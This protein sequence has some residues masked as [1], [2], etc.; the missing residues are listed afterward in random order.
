MGSEPHNPDLT[1]K[2]APLTDEEREKIVAFLDGEL[3]DAAEH[4]VEVDIGQRDHVRQ[5]VDS[6]RKTWE[7]LDFLPKIGSPPHFTAQTMQRLEMTKLKLIHREK[8]WRRLAVIGWILTVLLVASMAF[9]LAYY[10]PLIPYHAREDGAMGGMPTTPLS[11]AAQ[12]SSDLPHFEPPLLRMEGMNRNQER[13]LLTWI[14]Q[15]IFRVREELWNKLEP[16]ER[17]RLQEATRQGG[18]VFVE[19]LLELANKYKVPIQ[20]PFIPPSRPNPPRD[21][22]PTAVDPKKNTRPTKLD[23]RAAD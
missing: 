9:A 1:A 8:L 17:R 22:E 11:T 15:D 2:P 4:A 19:A 21:R 5:E 6:L 14:Y 7:L 13:L 16:F 20:R 3:D 23:T 12:H 10:W 18:L